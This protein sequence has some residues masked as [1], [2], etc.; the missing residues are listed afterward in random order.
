MTC[1]MTLTTR[2][3]LQNRRE[4]NS[5]A[6]AGNKADTNDAPDCFYAMCSQA[7]A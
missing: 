6:R 1:A 4:R 5:E 2:I 7:V 3:A